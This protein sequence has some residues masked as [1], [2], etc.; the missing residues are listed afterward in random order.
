MTIQGVYVPPL[1]L[2]C[3]A[4]SAVGLVVFGYA[5][6]L[7]VGGKVEDRDGLK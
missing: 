7:A 4:G 1:A 5:I 3:F 2:V 6:A